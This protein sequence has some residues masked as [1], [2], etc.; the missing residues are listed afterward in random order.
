M[1]TKVTR[2]PQ[3]TITSRVAELCV[4][5]QI[6]A[7]RLYCPQPSAGQRA[8]GMSGLLG[9]RKGGVGLHL[10]T[11]GGGAHAVAPFIAQDRLADRKCV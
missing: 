7:V 3:V 10:L 1:G 11:P 2:G 6:W 4:Q 9:H 5:A 8:M